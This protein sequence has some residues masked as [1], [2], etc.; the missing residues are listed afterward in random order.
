MSALEVEFTVEPFVEATIGPHVRAAIDAAE[1]TGVTVDI[2]PFSSSFV[3]PVETAVTAV[4]DLL[5]AAAA[6]GASRL[7]LQVR[8]VANRSAA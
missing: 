5:A 2:G 8:V 6:A 7:A 4:R 3:A 1:A